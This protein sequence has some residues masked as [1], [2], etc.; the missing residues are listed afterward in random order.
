MKKKQKTQVISIVNQKGGTGK[1]TTAV[2][3]AKAL[4]LLGYKILLVDFDPQGS[5]SYYLDVEDAHPNIANVLLGEADIKTALLQVSGMDILPSNTELADLEISLANYE[6]RESLLKGYLNEIKDHYDYIIIDCSPSLSLLTINALVASDY[7]I[8]PIPMEVLSFHGLHLIKN[9]VQAVKETLNP[10]LSILGILVVKYSPVRRIT[11]QLLSAIQEE[12]A[13]TL[14]FK[15]KIRLDTR[16][17]ES[18][19]YG[20]NIFE[21]ASNSKGAEDYLDLAKEIIHLT[22][23]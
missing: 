5:L 10:A 18:P 3:L 9:T 21:T 13:D 17:I 16:L 7:L 4:E 14:V 23:K 8:I 20:N 22:Q 2:N 11:T 19:A 15:T 1:T 6:G 12:F